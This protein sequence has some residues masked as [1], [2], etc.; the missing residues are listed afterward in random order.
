M[1]LNAIIKNK[2]QLIEQETGD[3]VV[4]EERS[5]I[6]VDADACVAFGCWT[7]MSLLPKI[8]HKPSIDEVHIL[9]EVI[10]LEKFFVE[11]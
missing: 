2:I 6:G 5:N 1:D 4:I 9:H 11:G 10:H 3:K 7:D 8:L